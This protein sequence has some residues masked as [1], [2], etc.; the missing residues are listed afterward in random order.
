[1][2]NRRIKIKKYA[3]LSDTQPN[4][5][6]PSQNMSNMIE[7]SYKKPPKI[8]KKLSLKLDFSQFESSD[9]IDPLKMFDYLVSLRKFTTLFLNTELPTVAPTTSTT[10]TPLPT[11]PDAMPRPS[12]HVYVG[13]L[14]PQAVK[15]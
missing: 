10:P 5:I 3:P 4:N 7:S 2:P 11:P 8:S 15:L 14:Q 12:I 9:K 6:E 13:G 1:M